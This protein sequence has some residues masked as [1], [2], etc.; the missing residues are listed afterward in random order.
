MPQTLHDVHKKL[1]KLPDQSLD[2]ANSIGLHHQSRLFV[3]NR[4]SGQKFL[5]D[6]GADIS[7]I[8]PTPLQKQKKT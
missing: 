7:V 5:I 1:G 8:P 6:T 2:T 3:T 4:L